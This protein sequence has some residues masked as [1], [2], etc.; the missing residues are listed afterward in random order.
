MIP[1]IATII[2]GLV[3]FAGGISIVLE[4]KKPAKKP[5]QCIKVNEFT[6][7]A[8]QFEDDPSVVTIGLMIGNKIGKAIT[9]DTQL[10]LIAASPEIITTIMGIKGEKWKQ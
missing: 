7:S 1:G 4:S 5:F 8:Q 6:I 9:F 10:N 2:C 3:I